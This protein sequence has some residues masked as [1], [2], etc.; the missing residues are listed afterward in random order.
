MSTKDVKEEKKFVV[1][2]RDGKQKPPTY[3]PFKS[4]VEG[5]EDMV[6]ENGAVKHAIANYMQQKYNSDIAR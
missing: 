2:S 1:R 5:L 6:F 3:K 4:K